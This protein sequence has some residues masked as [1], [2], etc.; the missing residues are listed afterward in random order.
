LSAVLYNEIVVFVEGLFVK[1]E[2]TDEV[3][4]RLASV[5]GKEM[6]LCFSGVKLIEVFVRP[7]DPAWGFW[8][9]SE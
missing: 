1:E 5:I 3:R 2:R 9:W 8:S 6:E 4:K 7:F